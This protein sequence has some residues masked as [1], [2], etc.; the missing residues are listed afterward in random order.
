M[1]GF[2]LGAAGLTLIAVAFLLVPLWRERRL[3]GKLPLSGML[4]AIAIIPVSIGVYLYVSTFDPSIDPTAGH[5]DLALLDQ[6]ATRLR[7]DPDNVDGWL[8]LG[9]SYRELGDYPRA[10]MAF[11]QAWQRTPEPDD[12]LKISYAEAML[13]TEGSPAALGAAGDLVEEVLRTSPRNQRALWWGGL[14]AA[15]RNQRSL[16]VERW[17]RL[18][19]TNPPA[20]ITTLIQQQ[21]AALGGAGLA[22]PADSGGVIDVESSIEQQLAARNASA[23]PVIDIE[24]SVGENVALDELG[25]TAALFVFARAPGGG[26]PIA[27]IRQP[28]SALPGNFRLSDADV[29][30]QGRSL[31]DFDEVALVARISRTGEPTERPGDYFAAAAV[32]PAAGEAV[33]LVIDQ[34]VP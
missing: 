17:T 33:T 23:G 16:A 26:P 7:D 14:V 1:T 13:F 32:D 21:L 2:W 10:R 30:L 31:A 24:I 6:L 4:T 12:G 15:E 11:E 27:V 34:V 20:E 28:L 3:A 9:R 29:M 25:P 19:E 5:E 22:A 8:L 18:L